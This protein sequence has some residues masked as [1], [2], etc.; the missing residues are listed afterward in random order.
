MNAF[1]CA[2][3]LSNSYL[4][5]TQ[6]DNF[7]CVFLVKTRGLVQSKTPFDSRLW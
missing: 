3:A 1:Y 7:K 2:E 4:A 5:V 6:T